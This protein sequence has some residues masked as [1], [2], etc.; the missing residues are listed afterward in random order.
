MMTSF[1]YYNLSASGF[2][3]FVQIRAFNLLF[4]A[5][6]ITKFKHERKNRKIYG[7]SCKMTPS[8]Q[9]SD[10]LQVKLICKINNSQIS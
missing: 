10:L 9:V 6:T 1:I 8:S 7:R 3:L 2:S 4:K 5:R